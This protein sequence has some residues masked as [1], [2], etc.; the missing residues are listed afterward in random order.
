[1]GSVLCVTRG[2]EGGIRVQKEAV[3]IAMDR[4]ETLV[5]LYV[6]DGSFLNRLA[7]PI[8]VDIKTIL[9]RMGWFPLYAA[10]ERASARSVPAES[11]TRYGVL[12]N[13]LPDVVSE[14]DAST[15]II[16]HL[17]GAP[18]CFGRVEMDKVLV[19]MRE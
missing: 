1:M 9:E 15:I 14:I 13:V 6:A 18:S 2:G 17:T 10:I 16:G 8:V 3:R 12:S 4:G 11:L 19:S 7:A 5:F